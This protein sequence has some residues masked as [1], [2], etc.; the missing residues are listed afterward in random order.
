MLT[1]H[2]DF[3]EAIEALAKSWEAMQEHITKLHRGQI[4]EEV[5]T[6]VE[7]GPQDKAADEAPQSESDSNQT[8]EST[9]DNSD[10]LEEQPAAGGQEQQISATGESEAVAGGCLDGS[11]PTVM[12]SPSA[13]DET[14]GCCAV[15]PA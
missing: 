1:T 14:A 5:S 9:S 6:M 15:Y 2:G 11:R 13:A 8:D 10:E 4:I 12:G 3:A 7:T